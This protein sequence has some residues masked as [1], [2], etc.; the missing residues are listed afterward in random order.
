LFGKVKI[1][2]IL[3]VFFEQLRRFGFW[4]GRSVLITF[5]LRTAATDVH[6]AVNSVKKEWAEHGAINVSRT[7]FSPTFYERRY[8]PGRRILFNSLDYALRIAYI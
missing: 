2:D 5:T 6:K 8:R 3:A 7:G 4:I 1:P